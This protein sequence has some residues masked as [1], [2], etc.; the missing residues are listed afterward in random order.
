MVPPLTSD[1]NF[2][3]PR[4]TDARGGRVWCLLKE[5]QGVGFARPIEVASM[6]KKR[7]CIILV[8]CSE[9]FVVLRL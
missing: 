2:A 6:S 5:R 4:R 1:R 9:P 8:R 3:G 7:A